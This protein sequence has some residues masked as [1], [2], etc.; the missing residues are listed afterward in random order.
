MLNR[1]SL[2]FLALALV[3]GAAAAV[4]ARNYVSDRATR[5]VI[6]PVELA[7]VVTAARDISVGTAVRGEDIE[8][9]E[10]PRKHL[11]EGALG[12]EAQVLG[13]VLRRAVAQ[14]EPLF[15][16]MLL[17][18]G[19]AAG[20]PALISDQ[21]RAVSVKVDAVVGVAGFIKPGARVDVLATLRTAD[22]PNFSNVILQDVRVLAV[23]QTLEQVN[24][25][26]PKV[27][28]VATL[29]VLPEEAEHLVHAAHEG[30]LQ[31][32]LRGPGDEELVKTRA[33]Q[34]TDLM[35]RPPRQ[36]QAA[37]RRPAVEVIKGTSVS[38]ES[39]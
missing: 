25:G 24:D 34:A 10:W 29:E 33:V 15:K 5:T 36:P 32:A 13:R 12:S 21:H 6:Q 38:R 39:L 22:A 3:F 16:S 30:R 11:P 7:P 9:L 4:T 14:G 26:D 1:R 19:T 8:T 18:Q 28:N 37:A 27:V 35:G 20:L 2:L 23:D 31:L 17:P